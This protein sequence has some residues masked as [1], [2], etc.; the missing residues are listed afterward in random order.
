M[1]VSQ[2]ALSN[3]LI[4][5]LKSRSA[6]MDLAAGSYSVDARR[7][8]TQVTVSKMIDTYGLNLTSEIKSKVSLFLANITK[9][10]TSD[11]FDPKTHKGFLNKDLENRRRKL[12]PSEKRWT[13]KKIEK[14]CRLKFH[15]PWTW[16]LAQQ[17]LRTTKFTPDM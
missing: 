12:P 11:Y 6:V 16:M 15:C 7:S 3:Y 10:K 5:H 13:W 14:M 2:E 8:I 17:Q 4:H 9:M 1:F